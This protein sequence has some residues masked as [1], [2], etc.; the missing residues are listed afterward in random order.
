M[1]MKKNQKRFLLLSTYVITHWFWS[2][3]L[4]SG[5]LF[6]CLEPEVD[7]EST[8][9]NSKESVSQVPM[10]VRWQRPRRRKDRHLSSK[11]KNSLV[12]RGEFKLREPELRY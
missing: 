1:S 3:T 4:L 5:T 9:D 12:E 11:T 7:L 8:W 10:E 2:M 6:N